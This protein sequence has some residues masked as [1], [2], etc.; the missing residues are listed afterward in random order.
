MCGRFAMDDKT[1]ELLEEFVA[2]H[3]IK[4]L[5]DWRPNYNIPPTTEVPVARLHDGKREVEMVRW[6]M[7]APSSKEFGGGKPVFNARIES[8][9]KLGL[10]KGPFEKR[11][12]IV[13]ALGYYEWQLTEDGKQPYFIRQPNAQLAMAGVVGAWRDPAKAQGDPDRW[14]LSMAIITMDAHVAPGEVHDRMPAFLTPDSY[15]D[16]LGDHLGPPDLLKLLDRTS[17]EVADSLEYHP[18]SHVVN[19][20]EIEK[21]VPNDGPELVEPIQPAP[22]LP[23]PI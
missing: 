21:G 16:W 2:E 13:P 19:K 14:R 4:A 1:N 15:D 10:F 3:G 18:V 17:S 22:I 8:V 6:G 20:V 23:G 5:K 9:D 11:R 7:I 12:C